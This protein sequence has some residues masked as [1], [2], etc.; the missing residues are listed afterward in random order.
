MLPLFWGFHGNSKIK[1]ISKTIIN[2]LNLNYYF[3]SERIFEQLM[4]KLFFQSQQLGYGSGD[5]KPRSWELRDKPTR[6]QTHVSI[7]I[8]RF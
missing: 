4:S 7:Y 1:T 5:L 8:D 2:F 6:I 3:D